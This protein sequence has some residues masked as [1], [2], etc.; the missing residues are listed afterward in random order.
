LANTQS[1]G[2]SLDGGLQWSLP[3]GFSLGLAVRNGGWLQVVQS[4]AD[5]LPPETLGSVAWGRAYDDASLHL[6]AQLQRQ[7]GGDLQAALAVEFGMGG[8]GFVRAS[9][10]PLQ[11]AGQVQPWAAGAGVRLGP[12]DLDGA[13]VPYGD[14]GN[15]FRISATY[16]PTRSYSP[17]DTALGFTAKDQGSGVYLLSWK[18]QDDAAGYHLYRK[19]PTLGTWTLV[20]SKLIRVTAVRM[21]GLSSGAQLGICAVDPRGVDG[22]MAVAVLR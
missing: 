20:T 15:T 14:L 21:R 17:A 16:F 2:W 19:D 18:A 22:A 13:W 11:P 7:A 5:Q 4:Q 1:S 12:L 3:Q 6:A 10:T 9:F 8:V